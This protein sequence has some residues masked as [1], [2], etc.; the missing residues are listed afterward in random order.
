MPKVRSRPLKA[1]KQRLINRQVRNSVIALMLVAFHATD[2][3]GAFTT[4]GL[5]FNF[6]DG[7]E[8]LKFKNLPLQVIALI[9][10]ALVAGDVMLHR[11]LDGQFFRCCLPVCRRHH[12]FP[13]VAMVGQRP[14]PP[15]RLD[16]GSIR[17]RVGKVRPAAIGA[18]AVL[19]NSF[20]SSGSTS[21]MRYK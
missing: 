13:P 10:D 4:Q 3:S 2:G 8:L 15:Q 14:A 21:G 18:V 1:D 11:R 5:Y 7:H 6:V 12:I 17:F 9:G 19:L 20:T 16:A